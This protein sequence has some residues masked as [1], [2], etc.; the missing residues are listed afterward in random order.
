MPLPLFAQCLDRSVQPNRYFYVEPY[1]DGLTPTTTDDLETLAVRRRII[2][3]TGH[4]LTRLRFRVISITTFPTTTADLRLLSAPDE[5]VDDPCTGEAREVK[6]M[7]LEQGTSA[8][9][10]N[11]GG[12]NSTATAASVTPSNPLPAF[13]DPATLRQE[14]ALDIRFLLGV[15]AEGNVPLLHR[16][17]DAAVKRRRLT[18]MERRAGGGPAPQ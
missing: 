12:F 3:S 18:Y 16:H 15:K 13:D 7:T 5:F 11:G 2:N 10:P 4:P 9:Q 17:G 1:F 8:V 14:N 6:G